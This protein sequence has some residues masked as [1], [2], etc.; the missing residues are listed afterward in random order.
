M[1][2]PFLA[3]HFLLPLK[4]LIMPHTANFYIYFYLSVTVVTVIS[5]G[6]DSSHFGLLICQDLNQQFPSPMLVAAVGLLAFSYDF[7][8][9]EVEHKIS[10]ELVPYC[11]SSSPDTLQAVVSSTGW[12]RKLLIGK[13]LRGPL[14]F[15][16]ST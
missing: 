15:T 5:C 2:C 1:R 16:R 9:V 14:H 11:L 13:Q 7:M 4:R 8:N 6:P 3:E 10:R 12:S